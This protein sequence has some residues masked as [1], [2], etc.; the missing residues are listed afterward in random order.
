MHL[1]LSGHPFFNP[2]ASTEYYKRIVLVLENVSEEAKSVIRSIYVS[3]KH[4]EIN[5]RD[6][7]EMLERCSFKGRTGTGRTS[8]K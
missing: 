7:S 2:T 3:S 6:A 1:F 4:D 8:A 5:S